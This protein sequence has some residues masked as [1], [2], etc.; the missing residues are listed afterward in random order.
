MIGINSDTLVTLTG[1]QDTVSGSYI[2]DAVV[3]AAIIDGDTTLFTVTLSYVAASSG[4]YRGTF[5][6]AQTNT[7]TDGKSYVVQTVATSSYGKLTL[8]AEELAG[9][10]TG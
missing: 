2:N 9:Y 4:N 1:H 3:T 10:T 5:T 7:L 8:R 6:S